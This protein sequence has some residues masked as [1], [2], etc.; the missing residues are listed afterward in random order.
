MGKTPAKGDTV[1]W[2]TP[3]GET[4]GK[5]EKIVTGRTKVGSHEVKASEDEPQVVVKSDKT[6]KKAAHKPSALKKG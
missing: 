1:T 3:Q 2:K 4:K 5:V 6:G